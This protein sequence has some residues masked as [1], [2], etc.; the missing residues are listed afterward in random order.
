MDSAAKSGA[1]GVAPRS[2]PF[3][4]YQGVSEVSVEAEWRSG[5]ITAARSVTALFSWSV[6]L[7]LSLAE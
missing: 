2:V 6:E 3:I 5:R 1:G 7:G 4:G